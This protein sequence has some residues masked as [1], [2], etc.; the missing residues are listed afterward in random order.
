MHGHHLFEN[1]SH[2]YFFD[3][4]EEVVHFYLLATVRS[5]LLMTGSLFMPIYIY[6]ETGSLI[7]AF[8]YFLGAQSIV[9]IVLRPTFNT[10]IFR[11]LGVEVASFLSI[12]LAGVEY[13]LAYLFGVKNV[14]LLTLYAVLE[15]IS[16]SLYWDAFHLSF[17]LFGKD[18]EVAEEVAGLQLL[19]NALSI[20][21]PFISVLFISLF[22]FHIFYLVV[23]FITLLTSFFLIKSFK[24]TTKIFVDPDRFK[25]I[26][27]KELFLIEG[28]TIG[29]SWFVPL[30]VYIVLSGNLAIIGGLKTLIG[31]VMAGVSYAIAAFVDRKHAYSLGRIVYLG[32]A[33]FIAF[34]SLVPDA[35]LVSLSEILRGAALTF[36]VAISAAVYNVARKKDK[37]L[38]VARNFYISIGKGLA[39][40]LFLALTFLGELSALR[41]TLLLALPF[42][43]TTAYMYRCLER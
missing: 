21:F 31:L 22:G 40:A 19:Q 34:I 16:R 1:V 17:G 7:L 2:I 39:L 23:F 15:G 42:G 26:P 43:L 4:P 10:F 33:I 35:F 11:R 5:I 3:L 37:T 8:L 25:N 27:C 6:N 9:Q 28:V 24:H 38:L 41:T 14:L 18:R 13:L 30:Y 20:A 36:A 32:N 29:I 12:V